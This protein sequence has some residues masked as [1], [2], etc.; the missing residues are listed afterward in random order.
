MRSRRRRRFAVTAPLSS[1][2]ARSE[3]VVFTELDDVVVMLDTDRGMYYE[4][5]AVASRIWNLL[6]GEPAVAGLS[7]ALTAEFDVDADACRADLLAFL[8]ELA[9]LG[10]VRSSASGADAE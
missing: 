3:A 4:L 2:I 7:D 5:D 10:L 9:G 1:R 6:E 8:G